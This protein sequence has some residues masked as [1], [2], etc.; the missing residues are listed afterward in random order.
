MTSFKARVILYFLHRFVC[1]N[2]NC[3]VSKITYRITDFLLEAIFPLK[4]TVFGILKAN[5][6]PFVT[7]ETTLLFFLIE[8]WC[9]RYKNRKKYFLYKVSFIILDD[10]YDY[11]DD[12][13]EDDDDELAAKRHPQWNISL[14]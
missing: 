11:D 8:L 7:M 1:L 9:S 12:G 14:L 5:D 10:D 4:D 6:C 3:Y 13:D 2:I